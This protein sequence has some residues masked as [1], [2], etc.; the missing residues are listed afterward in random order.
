MNFRLSLE[1]VL[2]WT[3]V[4]LAVLCGVVF[5]VSIAVGSEDAR[6]IAT[7]TT[8]IVAAV[9]AGVSL[10]VAI[11]QIEAHIR[12][13]VTV[14]TIHEVASLGPSG[15]T[16]TIPFELNACYVEVQNTGPVPAE[17][18]YLQVH[19]L[20]K[21]GETIVAEVC[22]ELPFLPPNGQETLELPD[23]PHETQADVCAGHMK[24]KVTMN[25]KGMGKRHSTEQTFD[26]EQ[27][28]IRQVGGA[29]STFTFKQ[30]RP[31]RWT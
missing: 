12:P 16:A 20:K 5:G 10:F 14:A 19:L 22:S 13:F 25:Y 24:I 29:R 4:A 7:T 3:I 26:I 28:E 11:F 31:S 27:A 17:D 21:A 23:I 1:K 15:E 6:Y 30:T 8:A 9:I 2:I 18:I